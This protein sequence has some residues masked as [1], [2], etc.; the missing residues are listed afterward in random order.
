MDEIPL[1][2]TPEQELEQME[3][4]LLYLARHWEEKI[5]KKFADSGNEKRA[6]DARMYAITIRNLLASLSTL[7]AE[8]GEQD[9]HAC[10]HEANLHAMLAVIK[11]E[12]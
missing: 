10:V 9:L 1:Q 5:A 3:F 8:A 6:R 2:R 11:K 4:A 12:Q 7:P